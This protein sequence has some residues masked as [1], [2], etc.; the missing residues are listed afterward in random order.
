MLLRILIKRKKGGKARN[1]QSIPLI[2]NNLKMEKGGNDTSSRQKQN[3]FLQFSCK[4]T[5]IFDQNYQQL[6]E[7]MYIIIKIL[8]YG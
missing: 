2:G 5:I 3:S 1:G 7:R 6:P 4:I 8:I